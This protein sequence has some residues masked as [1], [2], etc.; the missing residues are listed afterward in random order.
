L[1]NTKKNRQS[2]AVSEITNI[3]TLD[4]KLENELVSLYQ[5]LEGILVTQPRKIIQFLGCQDKE[6][7]STI[8]R[9]FAVLMAREFKKT[10][11]LLDAGMS[12]NTQHSQLGIEPAIYL[13]DLMMSKDPVDKALYQVGNSSLFYS[14][15]LHSARAH[16]QLLI[17]DGAEH[18]FKR[19]S[20]NF[21]YVIIDSPPASTNFAISLSSA[22]VVS[23][24][25]LVLEAE[26]TRWP[27]V[28]NVKARIIKN[29][30]KL[31][32]I[33]LNKRRY[34]L[35]NFIYNRL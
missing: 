20:K 3:E 19:V 29:E 23:G 14:K 25:V 33:V 24:V 26:K 2:T 11:L 10:T 21:D 13:E 7:V 9:E 17:T 18:L 28:E 31:L 1:R 30:G 22:P 5:S 6:G 16:P 35:P 32:G 27:V 4:L 8:A 34:H 15:L 12:E